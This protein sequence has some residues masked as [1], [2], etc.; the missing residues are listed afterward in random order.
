MKQQEITTHSSWNGD[1]LVGMM[2][3]C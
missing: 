3:Y 2:I 1:T